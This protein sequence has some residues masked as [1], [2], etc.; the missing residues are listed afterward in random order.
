AVTTFD[1]DEYVHSMRRAGAAGFLLKDT[2]PDELVAA[3]HTVAAG[4]AAV[5]PQ[6][7]RRLLRQF[8]SLLPSS[9]GSEEE[10]DPDPLTAREHQVLRLLAREIGR[11]SCRDGVWTRERHA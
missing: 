7:L 2:P 6:V 9:T 8:G 4:G 5:S 3:V 10:A 1:L 11:A